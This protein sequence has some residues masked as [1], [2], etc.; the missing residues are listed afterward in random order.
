MPA[1]STDLMAKLRELGIAHTTHHHPPV[2]TVEEA[3]EHCGDLPGQHCKNLFLKDKKGAL[4]LVVACDDARINM[5][6]LDK[7][8]GS[9]RLSFGRGDLLVEVLGVI[10]GAVTPF[11]LINDTTQRVRVV[12]DARMMRADLVNFHPLQNDSTTALTPDGLLQF[13]RNCG[14]EP[15]ITV[16]DD[17]PG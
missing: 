4:W 2:F 14:H 3:R 11:A 8:I 10:P 7:K 13:I 12:L 5:K 16:L 6:S 17:D 1:T 15:Q 9:A